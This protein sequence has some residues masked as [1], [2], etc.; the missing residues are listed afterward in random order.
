MYLSC[1]V[2]HMAFVIQ[3][4]AEMRVLKA[5]RELEYCKV[6]ASTFRLQYSRKNSFLSGFVFPMKMQKYD[7]NNEATAVT[8]LD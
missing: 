2:M 8:D 3:L 4:K 5:Y 6:H 1:S 7:W